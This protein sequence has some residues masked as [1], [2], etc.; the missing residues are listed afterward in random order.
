MTPNLLHFGLKSLF[1]RLSEARR[2]S[3]PGAVIP[4]EQPL[5]IKKP[6]YAFEPKK[7]SVTGK[8]H[9]GQ[10]TLSVRVVGYRLIMSVPLLWTWYIHKKITTARAPRPAAC[11]R[12]RCFDPHFQ[13]LLL[14][15]RIQ[16]NQR[17]ASCTNFGWQK[18]H[19][20][21]FFERWTVS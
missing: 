8:T 1:R 20:G 15:V 9:N 14:L 19:Y 11:C 4:F 3:E 5:T 16:A 21:T 12:Q 2:M 18:V 6:K 17:L 7:T 10:K 13:R